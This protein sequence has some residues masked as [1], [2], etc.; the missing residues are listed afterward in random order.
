[1]QGI[2]PL[3]TLTKTAVSQL[4]LVRISKSWSHMKAGIQE[5]L[6]MVKKFPLR[7]FSVSVLFR[8]FVYRTLCFPWDNWLRSEGTE[9]LCK[10]LKWWDIQF[11]DPLTKKCS[12]RYTLFIYKIFAH[13]FT[14]FCLRMARHFQKGAPFCKAKCRGAS[15]FLPHC[16]YIPNHL[17]NPH[18]IL[19]AFY[20]Q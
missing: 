8:E 5:K 9:F 16:L 17:T 15:S 13:H 18:E 10:S 1:M 14:H 20:H 7:G 6:G 11:F 3:P 2:F 12:K 19:H 4:L